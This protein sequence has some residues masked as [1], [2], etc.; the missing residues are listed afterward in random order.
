MN[1]ITVGNPNRLVKS[2]Q[3]KE[4]GEA[5]FN[6]KTGEIA[7]FDWDNDEEDWKVLTVDEYPVFEC[8]V[9]SGFFFDKIFIDPDGVQTGRKNML[10]VLKIKRNRKKLDRLC[11]FT[12]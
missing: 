8:G 5:M 4:W 2:L 11:N 1:I 10:C 12:K 9:Y 3:T 7:E 6:C